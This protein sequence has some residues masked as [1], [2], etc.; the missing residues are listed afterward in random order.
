MLGDKVSHGEV[1]SMLLC[2]TLAYKTT[3]KGVLSFVMKGKCCGRNSFVAI[4]R[5][6]EFQNETFLNDIKR[7][8]IEEITD[9]HRNSCRITEFRLW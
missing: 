2:V 6:F 4:L 1:S 5:L 3:K 7:N 9:L 8:G